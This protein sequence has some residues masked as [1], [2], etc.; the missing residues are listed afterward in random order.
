MTTFRTIVRL[1]LAATLALALAALIDPE[2]FAETLSPGWDAPADWVRAFG[3]FYIFA[4]AGY[5][6][7][8]I[9]PA[10]THIANMYPLLAPIV[11]ALLFLWLGGLFAWAA[12]FELLFLVL[13]HW[14]FRRDALRWL[15]AQP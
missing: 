13:L 12:A 8:A 11:P 1:K 14:S 15:M 6:P 7:S 5:A 9:A 2:A 10:R 3:A 4:A